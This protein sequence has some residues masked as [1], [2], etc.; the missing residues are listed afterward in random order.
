MFQMV[1]AA[2]KQLGCAAKKCSS[3]NAF[4]R[5]IKNALYLVCYYYPR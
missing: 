1:W 3:L 5:N 4:G 2:T